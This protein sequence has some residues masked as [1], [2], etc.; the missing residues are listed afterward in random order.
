M[1]SYAQYLGSKKCCDLRG[2]GPQGPAGPT[3]AQGP[4]GAYGQTGATGNIGNTGPTGRSCRGDTGPAGPAGPA[5]GPTGPTGF[6]G[7]TGNI[8]DTGPTGATGPS[9]WNSSSFIGPTGAG[10]TGIGYTGDVM[11]YGAL[12]VQGGIDPTYL[13]LTPQTSGPSGFPN[14]LWVDNSGNLRSEKILLSSGTDTLAIDETSITHSNATTPLT[15]SSNNSIH[16]DNSTEIIIGNVNSWI[17]GSTGTALVLCDACVPPQIYIQNIGQTFIGDL[18]SAGNSSIIQIDDGNA[19]LTMSANSLVQMTSS[20]ITLNAPTGSINLNAIDGSVSLDTGTSG[21]IYL[22]DTTGNSVT[23]D[24]NSIF[25]QTALGI[26]LAK[27]TIKYP[28]NVRGANYN[29]T[30]FTD[31]IQT[32]TTA[33]TVTLFIVDDERSGRQFLITNTSAGNLTVNSSS[34]QLIYT[35]GS[36]PATTRTLASGATRQFTAI[37]TTG[38]SVYGWSMI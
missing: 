20:V 38:G 21:A 23:I 19:E 14:P 25:T 15:I 1:S 30:D 16:I 29:F 4:I 22:G 2:L 11:V 8:G 26:I 36:T 6:T 33:S 37:R 10:Y 13:A 7:P 32:F 27:S 9:Q 17:A 35:T 24:T 34:G 5:G 31:A 3:G 12:Y 28:I 18:N